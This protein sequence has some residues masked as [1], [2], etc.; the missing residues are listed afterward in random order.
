MT[1]HWIVCCVLAGMTCPA[2][3]WAQQYREVGVEGGRRIAV[4]VPARTSRDG[5]LATYL[6]AGTGTRDDV[7]RY[8]FAD[9]D[10][11][12]GTR[13][14]RRTIAYSGR[15]DPVSREVADAPLD[16]L[17]H[18]PELRDLFA[19]ACGQ[20]DRVTGPRF[21]TIEDWLRHRPEEQVERS[22]PGRLPAGD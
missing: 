14:I 5:G 17:D 11:R 6:I 15:R 7:Y 21:L 13:Q 10:C 3:A 22:K 1:R 19:A 12:A 2:A 9:F 8:V 20:G 18:H 16:R 4:E